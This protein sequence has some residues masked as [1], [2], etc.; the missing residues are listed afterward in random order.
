MDM[1]KI[2]RISLRAGAAWQQSHAEVM[3]KV[4]N[5]KRADDRNKKKI[6]TSEIFRGLIERYNTHKIHT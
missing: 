6:L 5:E 4:G 3:E 2:S 1:Q